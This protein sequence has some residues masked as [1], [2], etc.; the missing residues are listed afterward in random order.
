M[1]SDLNLMFLILYVALN[2]ISFALFGADK[3]KAIKN[4]YRIRESTLLISGLLG[5]FG[6]IAGIKLF[7]HKTKKRKFKV[8]Y[9]F[10]ILHLILIFIILKHFWF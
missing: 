2:I 10:L 7:R 6:A 1:I 3:R 5:P 4:E 9:L 8:I